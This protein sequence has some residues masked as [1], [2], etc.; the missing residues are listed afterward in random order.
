MPLHD[1]HHHVLSFLILSL[2]TLISLHL[3][4]LIF[5]YLLILASILKLN[6][7][8]CYKG[9][10]YCRA[11]ALDFIIPH[12]C[13]C[14]CV[15]PHNATTIFP[16]PFSSAKELTMIKKEISCVFPLAKVC[17][18]PAVVCVWETISHE[19]K[20]KWCLIITYACL[21]E[22]LSNT[23]SKYKQNHQCWHDANA[24]VPAVRCPNLLRKRSVDDDWFHG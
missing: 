15:H 6:L 24:T 7:R 18:R 22:W 21:K 20:I 23:M 10:I 11:I 13:S 5:C 17:Y 3:F 8:Y 14:Y 1:F 16:N 12:R 2:C 4:P 19:R 9:N